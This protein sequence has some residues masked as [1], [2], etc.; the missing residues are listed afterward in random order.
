MRKLR[1]NLSRTQGLHRALLQG[2]VRACRQAQAPQ[3]EECARTTGS[4][5]AGQGGRAARCGGP[6]LP[7]DA[8]ACR[9]P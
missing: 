6:L 7:Q 5:Q 2:A 1:D 4:P 9:W 8:G 3:E